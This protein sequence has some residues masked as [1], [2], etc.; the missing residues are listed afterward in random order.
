MVDRQKRKESR[1]RMQVR[2]MLRIITIVEQNF[3]TE[4]VRMAC[5]IRLVDLSLAMYPQDR[6]AAKAEALAFVEQF[7][8]YEK[9][10]FQNRN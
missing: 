2:K 4:A 10:C 3:D 6:E 1:F 7:F 8:E 9:E 5:I